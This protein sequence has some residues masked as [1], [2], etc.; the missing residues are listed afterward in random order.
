MK[1]GGKIFV[2]M[3]NSNCRLWSKVTAAMLARDLDT[4]TTEKNL[5]E[6]RQ[7]QIKKDMKTDHDLY[8][9]RF[10]HATDEA[11]EKWK[12]ELEDDFFKS[13]DPSK[14]KERVVEFMFTSPNPE[15]KL[16]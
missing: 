13:Q 16:A 12:C 3:I 11:Q 8:S 1:Q 15:V 7:R 6:D 4:A 2:P 5:I 10:F 14:F 9:G